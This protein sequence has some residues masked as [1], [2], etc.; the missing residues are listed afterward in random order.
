MVLTCVSLMMSDVEHL[1]VHL[2]AICK[3]SFRKYLFSSSVYSVLKS[4][5]FGIELY[6]FLICFS[7]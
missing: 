6:E 2:L 1:F 5:F 7:Y 4:L 3:L